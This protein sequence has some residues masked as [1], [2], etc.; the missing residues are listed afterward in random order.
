M[1]SRSTWRST[2]ARK[3]TLKAGTDPKAM[4]TPLESVVD[5]ARAAE[6]KRQEAE[7]QKRRRMARWPPGVALWKRALPNAALFVAERDR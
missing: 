2:V 1:T 3:S 5:Q 4:Q 6:K 7:E